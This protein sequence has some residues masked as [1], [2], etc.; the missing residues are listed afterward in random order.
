MK[1]EN[2]GILTVPGVQDVGEIDQTDA[3]S[4]AEKMGRSIV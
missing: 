2:Q 4:Q 1:W 3:L